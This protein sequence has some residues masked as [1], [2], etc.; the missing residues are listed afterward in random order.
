LPEELRADR[1]VLIGQPVHDNHKDAEI[2]ESRLSDVYSEFDPLI[3]YSNPVSCTMPW[4]RFYFIKATG[5][6]LEEG[7]GGCQVQASHEEDISILYV[8]W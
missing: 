4:F 8:M 2:N 3:L 7:F 1:E 5:Y 6:H